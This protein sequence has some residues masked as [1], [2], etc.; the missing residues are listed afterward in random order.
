MIPP[1]SID[2]TDI[3]GATIDGQDVQEITVDG[4][5]VFSATVDPFTTL[6]LRYKMDEG[7]G[8]SISD[9]IGSQDG[10]IA[11][12][13]WVSDSNYTGGFAIDINQDGGW[14]SNSGNVACNEPNMT[15]MLWWNFN[16]NDNRENW[17]IAMTSLDNDWTQSNS[18]G[19]WRINGDTRNFPAGYQF[20]TEGASGNTAEIIPPT[21]TGWYFHAAALTPTGGTYYLF[22]ENGL[23]QS[24]PIG[25]RAA[26]GT[27]FNFGGGQLGSASRHPEGEFDDI[28]LSTDTTLTQQQ[29]TTVYNQ[30]F[31]P[32][33]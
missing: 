15:V 16:G 6:D 1:T 33:V 12:A 7:S 25:Q 8:S 10:F 21:N 14:M 28:M 18:V 26:V 17:A 27:T 9:S 24:E 23:F 29:I 2:G 4:D 31:R 13:S 5:T 20:I 30:T 19:G 11:N 22:D 32:R 3:T